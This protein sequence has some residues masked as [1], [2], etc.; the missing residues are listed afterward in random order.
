MADL[1]P[2]PK[3]KTKPSDWLAPLRRTAP[4]AAWPSSTAL[5]LLQGTQDYFPALLTALAQAQHSIYFETY[6]FDPTGS[7][8]AVADALVAAAERGVAV[9]MLLDG[10]GSGRLSADCRQR[11]VDAGVQ[12]RFYAPPTAWFLFAP[13]QWQRLHR[14]LCAVDGR[15]AFCGGIN[16]LDDFYDPNHGQLQQPRL[17]FSVQVSDATAAHIAQACESLWHKTSPSPQSDRPAP[18]LAQWRHWGRQPKQAALLLRDNW[19]QRRSIERSYLKAMAKAQ[20]EVTIANAYFFPSRKLQNAIQHAA[21]RG[22]RV[23]LLLQGRYEYFLQFHASRAFYAPLLEAGV[24]IYEYTASFLH[25]KVATVDPGLPR[26]WATVGSSNL[27]PLSLLLAKEANIVSEDAAFALELQSRLLAALQDGRALSR[28][29]LAQRSLWQ[30]SLDA[31]AYGLARS[32][33]WLVKD[34]F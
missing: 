11:L 30:R 20:A 21:R 10:I 4:P 25:A 24:E 12:L 5:R 23:R 2:K 26:T 13:K 14:K 27:D 31:L 7:G 32:M 3:P 9:H 22:V 29:E 19:Q 16:M 1:K 15:I 8:Q 33:V 34:S 18:K 28:A 17:D 6:I